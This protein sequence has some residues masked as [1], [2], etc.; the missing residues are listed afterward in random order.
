[1]IDHV[2]TLP[3]ATAFLTSV[4]QGDGGPQAFYERLGFRLTG[5]IDDGE[6]V[7]RLALT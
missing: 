7:M 1:L 2:R 3:N 4:V 5:E 6:A